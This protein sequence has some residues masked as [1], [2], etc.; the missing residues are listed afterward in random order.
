MWASHLE[1][2][3]ELLFQ[4]DYSWYHLICTSPGGFPSWTPTPLSSFPATQILPT[5]IVV[6]P[7]VVQL[8]AFSDQGPVSRKSRYLNGPEILF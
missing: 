1:A 7:N 6:F 3:L 2:G 4:G 5:V 8:V